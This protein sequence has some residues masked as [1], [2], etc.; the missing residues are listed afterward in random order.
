MVFTL[1]TSAKEWLSGRFGQ[2]GADENT[3]DDELAKD[4]VCCLL[5]SLT[6]IDVDRLHPM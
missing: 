1:V 3:A 5:Y 4:E 6:F 2:D